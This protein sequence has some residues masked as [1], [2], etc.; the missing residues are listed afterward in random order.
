MIVLSDE[1][2]KKKQIPDVTKQMVEQFEPLSYF[3]RLP[4]LKNSS[5]EINEGIDH[6]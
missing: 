2:K 4:G 6:R 5:E 3:R 1:K